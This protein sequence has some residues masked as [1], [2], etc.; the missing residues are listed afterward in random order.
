NNGP[1]KTR[2]PRISRTSG[3]LIQTGYSGDA[4]AI[5]LRG[6]NGHKYNYSLGGR[7]SNSQRI[8]RIFLKNKPNVS[9]DKRLKDDFSEVGLG[10]DFIL[11]LKPTSFKF[12]KTQADLEDN[13]HEFGFIAQEV[14]EAMLKHNKSID[15]YSR[16]NSYDGCFYAMEHEQLIAPMVNSI[17]ELNSKIKEEKKKLKHS[18]SYLEK[19]VQSLKE[20]IIQ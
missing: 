7:Q 15:K 8:S 4:S 13:K 19:E 14:E 2:D 17:Q 9:S 11:D 16:I 3:W 18:V 5:T 6:L 12:K 10:L 1:V 20:R